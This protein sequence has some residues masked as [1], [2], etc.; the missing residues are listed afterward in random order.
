MT[1]RVLDGG[2][3]ERKFLHLAPD[4]RVLRGTSTQTS[5]KGATM[6]DTTPALPVAVADTTTRTKHQLRTLQ[7]A[8]VETRKYTYEEKSRRASVAYAMTFS[9][10]R[11]SGGKIEDLQHDANVYDIQHCVTD[12][13]LGDKDGNRLDLTNPEV[14]A[15]L[16]PI[17]GQELNAI[18]DRENNVDERTLKLISGEV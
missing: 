12:H 9:R 16:D 17:V 6:S 5:K 11:D 14:I 4:I 18:I 1:I 7:G 13:N 3:K 8:W 2:A 15:I 10:D